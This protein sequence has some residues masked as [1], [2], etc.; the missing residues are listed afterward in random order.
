MVD[1]ETVLKF[2]G[3]AKELLIKDGEL[4][5]IAFIFKGHFMSVA[6][7]IPTDIE[8]DKY[9]NMAIVGGFARSAQADCLLALF[10]GAAKHYDTPEQAKYAM[11]N[12]ETEAPLSYPKSMRQECIIAQVVDFKTRKAYAVLLNYSG[13]HPNF[14]FE[15]PTEMVVIEGAMAEYAFKGWDMVEEGIH[16]GELTEI[17]LGGEDGEGLPE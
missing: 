12:H 5:P 15:E 17:S 8:T 11:E 1:R 14:K 4:C 10:D 13:D 16:N 3:K 6:P 2:L 7:P 9:R